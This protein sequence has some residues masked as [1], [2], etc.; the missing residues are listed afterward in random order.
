MSGQRFEGPDCGFVGTVIG[1][2][3][4]ADRLKVVV[5]VFGRQTAIALDRGHVEGAG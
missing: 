2:D 5:G 4:E 3:A 1:D